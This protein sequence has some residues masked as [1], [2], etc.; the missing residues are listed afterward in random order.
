MGRRY[1]YWILIAPLPLF[2][3]AVYFLPFL[4]V[5]R[6]SFTLGV[7]WRTFRICIVVT[8]VTT[9]LAYALSYIWVFGSR[10][11]QTIVEFGVL[12]PFWIS[13]LT[14]AFGWLI[15]LFNQGLINTGLRNLGIIDFP[16]TLVRNELGVIIGMTGG[17]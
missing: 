5:A 16:L 3:A 14:R 12:I 13:T 11:Q 10:L 7:L 1:G 6:W 8:L 9:I 15:L 4:G 17:C 2:L